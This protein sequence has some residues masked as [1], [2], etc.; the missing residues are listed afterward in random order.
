MS[1][2]RSM[3]RQL[4]ENIVKNT[5]KAF[6][7]A[8]VTLA[9]V[10]MSCAKTVNKDED[11]SVTLPLFSAADIAK[12]WTSNCVAKTDATL[13]TAYSK[14]ELT[15]NSNG[16]YTSSEYVYTTPSGGSTCSPADYIAIL[17]TGGTFS[18][19]GTVTGGQQINFVS[20]A[21]P[22]LMV[23]GTSSAP[24]TTTQNKF[25]TDCGGTSPYC[26][27]SGGTCTNN[28]TADGAGQNSS[29]MLCQHYTFPHNGTTMTNV[30]SYDGINFYMGAPT[31]GV[32]GVFNASS[33]PSSAT[34]F[35]H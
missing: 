27:L 32:P 19:G 13:G 28:G 5:S 29:S 2:A 35:L 14:Y 8:L 4:R 12:A 7:Y 6:T 21:S 30:V 26:T 10:I 23:R 33:L 24:Y 1:S 20:N 18:V 16:T 3:E 15:L 25:N 17:S 9:T 34:I 11:P 22:T 31:T